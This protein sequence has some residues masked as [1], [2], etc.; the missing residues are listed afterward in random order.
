MLKEHELQANV[1][2]AF[3]SSDKVPQVLYSSI[4]TRSTCFLLLLE[5]TMT[6]KSYT[7]C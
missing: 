5:N 1:S 6:R 7:T 3:S 2:T 4:E